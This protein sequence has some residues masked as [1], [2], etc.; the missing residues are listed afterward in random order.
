MSPSF[1]PFLFF[2]L[3]LFFYFFYSFFFYWHCSLFKSDFVDISTINL[4][5]KG[6]SV[7]AKYIMSHRECPRE[8]LLERIR[9]R[10]PKS[11]KESPQL[12]T[13][14]P[15]GILMQVFRPSQRVY[16]SRSKR[17][18]CKIFSA[19]GILNLMFLSQVEE[20]PYKS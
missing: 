17:V 20:C 12:N 5:I 14:W 11:V 15:K 16:L 6:G 4:L 7:E 19:K 2:I 3:L 10:V 18:P 1:F 8:K 13:P 9:K